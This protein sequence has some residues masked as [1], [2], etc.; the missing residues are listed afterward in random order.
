MLEEL[1]QK[2]ISFYHKPEKENLPVIYSILQQTKLIE[3]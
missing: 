2:L 1:W 3:I